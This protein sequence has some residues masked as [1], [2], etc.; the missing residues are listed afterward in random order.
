MKTK[1]IIFSAKMI[2]ALLDGR[3]TQTRRIVKTQP[4][5]DGKWFSWHGHRP[6]SIYG[7]CGGNHI[8]A[9]DCMNDSSP[10]GQPGDLLWVR[11]TFQPI[12]L[13]V[14]C[15][16][17]NYK[18]GDGYRIVYTA[19]DETEEFIDITTDKISCARKPSIHMPRWASR[20]TLRIT[21]VRVERVQEITEE[22]AKAEG[23]ERTD[24]KYSCEPYRNYNE[25]RMSSGKN[26]SL[27]I[28]SFSTLWSSIHGPDAWDRNDWVWIIEFEVIKQNVDEVI[29]GASNFAG[30]SA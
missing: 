3:K 5:W 16:D 17:A 20:L 22:D 4:T 30:K 21:S 10:Y 11:E 26:C 27:A 19:T 12:C 7:A 8:G 23:I 15:D 28:M 13:D 9:K 2:R 1:P 18:T 25:P 6:N 29:A 24:W 14:D